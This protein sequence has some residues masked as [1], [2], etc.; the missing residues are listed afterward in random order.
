MMSETL[1]EQA[2]RCL[3]IGWR[4]EAHKMAEVIGVLETTADGSQVW[5]ENE[6]KQTPQCAVKEHI[7][8]H[9]GFFIVLA[10]I[11]NNNFLRREYLST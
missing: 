9:P 5:A 3:H 8:M 7:S 11:L 10:D 6:R 4:I 1:T 2:D